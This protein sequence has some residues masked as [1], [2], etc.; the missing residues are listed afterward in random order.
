MS[1]RAGIRGYFLIQ[2]CSGLYWSANVAKHGWKDYRIM[3]ISSQ[4]TTNKLKRLGLIDVEQWKERV[5]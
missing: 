1:E 2:A 3:A 5:G 4:N